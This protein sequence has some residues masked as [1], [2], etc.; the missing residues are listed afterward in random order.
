MPREPRRSGNPFLDDDDNADDAK[1][2][3]NVGDDHVISAPLPALQASAIPPAD[4]PQA[5]S[6]VVQSSQAEALLSTRPPTDEPDSQVEAQQ[7][8]E[9]PPAQKQP[10]TVAQSAAAA[11]A[12]PQASDADMHR[13]LTGQHSGQFGSTRQLNTSGSMGREPALQAGPSG[14]QSV[15]PQEPTGPVRDAVPFSNTELAPAA[16]QAVSRQQSIMAQ[17]TGSSQHSSVTSAQQAVPIKQS[18]ER[19]SSGIDGQ[20]EIAQMPLHSESASGLQPEQLPIKAARPQSAHSMSPRQ[21]SAS[22]RPALDSAQQAVGPDYGQH[23]NP[24]M[25]AQAAPTQTHSSL[26]VQRQGSHNRAGAEAALPLQIQQQQQQVPNASPSASSLQPRD[27]SSTGALLPTGQQGGQ[28]AQ[29]Q[30]LHQE[31]GLEGML[32]RPAPDSE[33]EEEESAASAQDRQR[34]MQS[35]QSP[36]RGPSR[37]KNLAKGFGRMR[38]KAK[39]MLQTRNAES[40]R[41]GRPAPQAQS[42]GV[43]A[44]ASQA[45]TDAELGRGG[46]FARDMTMMFAGLKKP[47]GTNQQ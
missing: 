34:F 27:S 11:S 6:D 24:P 13:Q 45:P 18:A 22:I 19:Q 20:P 37:T 14:N 47:S 40:P 35:L 17:D 15:G 39:D 41:A 3:D 30:G 5:S 42:Q 28:Q 9:E 26:P 10:S 33:G 23:Q 2:N 25:H 7:A 1:K 38:A 46:R 16:V 21:Q 4:L 31:T 8:P 32:G 44:E 43:A 36:E 12:A 29:A